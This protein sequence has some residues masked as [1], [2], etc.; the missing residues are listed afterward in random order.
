[1]KKEFNML[2]IIMVCAVL[3]IVSAGL[4]GVMYTQG[5]LVAFLANTPSVTLADLQF[6]VFFVWLIIGIIAGSLKQ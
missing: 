5:P 1:M 6:M 3:G 4:I 2:I